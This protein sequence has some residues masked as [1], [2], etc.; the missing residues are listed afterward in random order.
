MDVEEEPQI[1]I[2]ILP[3]PPVISPAEQFLTT[4]AEPPKKSVPSRDFKS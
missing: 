1:K 2:N 4:E 3:P